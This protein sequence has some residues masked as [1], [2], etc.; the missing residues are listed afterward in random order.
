MAGWR[1]VLLVGKVVVAAVFRRLVAEM[2]R[3]T[4]ACRRGS[5]AERSGEEEVVVGKWTRK[6]YAVREMMQKGV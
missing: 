5:R 1:S 3:R 2:V 4:Q 6:E